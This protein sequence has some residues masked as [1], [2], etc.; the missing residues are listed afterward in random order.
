MLNSLYSVVQKRFSLPKSKRLL[1]AP[2]FD[3]IFS[4]GRRFENKHCRVFVTPAVKS[5]GKVAFI[6]SKKVGISAKRNSLK[7]R[8][9]ELFRLNQHHISPTIDFVLSAKQPL[10]NDPFQV[11]NDHF[12]ALLRKNKLLTH[13]VA[14]H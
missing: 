11:V 14:T 2:E 7:R 9:R 4:A 3:H 1:T 10:L 8:L 12:I 6:C 13:E 5:E